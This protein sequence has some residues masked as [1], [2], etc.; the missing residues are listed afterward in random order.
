MAKVSVIVP[1]HN[2]AGKLGNLKAWLSEASSLEL[3]VLIVCNACSDTTYSE[4]SE[5]VRQNG[6]KSISVFEHN[7][8]GAGLARNFAIDFVETEFTVFWDSDDVG[9]PEALLRILPK[10]TGHDLLVANY[11]IINS[12]TNKP[13]VGRRSIAVNEMSFSLEPGIWRCVFRTSFI[14]HSKFGKSN[15]GE[16]Q[17]FLARILSQSP[18]ILYLQDKIYDY[19]VGSA[20][21][22]TSKT[23][24]SKG[25]SISLNEIEETFHMVPRPFLTMSSIFYIKQCLSGI[26]KGHVQFKI[27]MIMHL[28]RF[29]LT[30]QISSEGTLRKIAIMTRSVLGNVHGK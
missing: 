4:I 23:F 30:K 13:L 6:L 21:Q 5:Y 29:A 8:R 7:L 9:Y 20:T 19:Y 16:D 3:K 17:V 15:M 10:S 2:M 18:K 14:K 11:E 22:L 12:K 1:I 27:K 26:K 24:D 25:I 28:L